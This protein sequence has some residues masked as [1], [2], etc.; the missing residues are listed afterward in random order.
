MMAPLV[1]ED[2][3]ISEPEDDGDEHIFDWAPLN[4][5][6][7]GEWYNEQVTTLWEPGSSSYSA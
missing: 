6:V 7:G 2:W 4:L 1:D 5:S 3:L